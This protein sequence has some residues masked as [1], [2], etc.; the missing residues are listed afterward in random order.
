[1][2]T[3]LFRK[4]CLA[5][6]VALIAAWPATSVVAQ[7][8]RPSPAQADVEFLQGM[9]AHHFQA[10]VMG[11]LVPKRTKHGP[12]NSLAERIIV[13]QRDEI[14]FMRQ[15]LLD[16][17]APAPDPLAPGANRHDHH[18]ELM[19]GMLT[20]EELATLRKATGTEF[21]RLL[22]QA[23][24]RHHEGAITMVAKLFDSPGGGQDLVVYRIAS[25]VEAD[26]RAEIARM[27][28]L[29]QPMVNQ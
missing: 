21:E 3:E 1:M 9:I 17:G 23:M 20:P 19:P 16:H 29:L 4:A 2:R 14:K 27:R 13:S 7:T 25:D 8:A 6:A 5:A 22:L 18:H 28:A 26:Q 24:I 12:I 10:I 11:E 15:W